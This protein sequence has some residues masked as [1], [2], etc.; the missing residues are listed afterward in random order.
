[1]ALS[2]FQKAVLDEVRKV[3]AGSVASY[4]QIAAYIGQPRAARQ[5]GGAMNSMEG[6]PDFPWWRIINNAGI[7]TIK[8]AVTANKRLQK[9]LLEAEGIE[10]SDDY[11]VDMARYRYLS[12]NPEV[13]WQGTDNLKLL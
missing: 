3:P 4:G 10:V 9:E 2:D 8:G 1:M 7:I 5:V 6:V 12:G 13:K 11:T